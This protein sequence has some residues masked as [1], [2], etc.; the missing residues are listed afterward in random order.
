[1]ST[2]R[3]AESRQGRKL[4]TTTQQINLKNQPQG[5]PGGLV[6]YEDLLIAQYLDE[7]KNTKKARQ[8]RDE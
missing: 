1:M 5:G 7:L 3:W 8:A 2:V 6:S 4:V